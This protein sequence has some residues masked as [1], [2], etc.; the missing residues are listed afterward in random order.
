[1]AAFDTDTR[2]CHRE[3]GVHG[4]LDGSG[5]SEFDWRMYIFLGGQDDF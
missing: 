2:D 5:G 3:T 4:I 1:V